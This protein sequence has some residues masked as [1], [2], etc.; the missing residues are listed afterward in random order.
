MFI[1]GRGRPIYLLT[2]VILGF[3]GCQ[4][5]VSLDKLETLAAMDNPEYKG[6]PVSKATITEV[7]KVLKRYNDDIERQI[8]GIDELGGLYR[9]LALKY[10]DIDMLNTR[11]R[12]L[13][14][15]EEEAPPLYQSDSLYYSALAFE[16]MDMKIYR[17]A[18]VNLEK[19]IGIF[20]QN[21]LLYYYA[22][23]CAANIGKSFV[24]EE[25]ADERE[26]WERDAEA[27]YM[28]A[29]ELDEKYDDA[30]YALSVLLFYELERP[31]DA[32]KLL[33]KLLEAQARY[34]DARFLLA[35]VYYVTSRFDDAVE[36]YE[37]IERSDTSKARKLQA[38]L[39]KERIL[40]ELYEL[41]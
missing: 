22:G 19:A 13:L 24:R 8:A 3:M 12:G 20:P 25:M 6:E 11:I 18:L 27:Y 30:L 21:K 38:K 26:K 29:L 40:A 5:Q 23:I 35:T 4:K 1:N 33:E 17:E 9:S 37:L 36:Q 32:E 31:Y 10:L 34:T 14:L 41:R 39:N 16:Y 28:R 7:R 15:Q 2:L